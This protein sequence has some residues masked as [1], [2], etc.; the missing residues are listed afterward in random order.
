MARETEDLYTDSSFE[1]LKVETRLAYSCDSSAPFF[2]VFSTAFVIIVGKSCIRRNT[3]VPDNKKEVREC[4]GVKKYKMQ[5]HTF[6]FLPPENPSTVVHDWQSF[7]QCLL[8]QCLQL[9]EC[10]H[11]RTSP[12]LKGTPS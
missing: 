3:N 1:S 4:V 5:Q 6:L 9:S 2:Q 10:S 11:I 8:S 7:L 12:R